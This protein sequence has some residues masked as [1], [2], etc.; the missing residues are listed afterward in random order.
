M[1]E[2]IESN[3]P[4][5]FF[6]PHCNTKIKPDDE[7]EEEYEELMNYCEHVLYSFTSEG[8][9]YLSESA[10]SELLKKGFEIKKDGGFVEIDNPKDDDFNFQDIIEILDSKNIENYRFSYASTWGL[11]VNIGIYKK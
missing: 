9:D 5:A 3:N 1:V 7:K 8:V 11:E 6:C 4:D 2:I 10:E